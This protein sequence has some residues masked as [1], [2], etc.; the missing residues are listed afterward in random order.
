MADEPMTSGAVH[1]CE[2]MVRAEIVDDIYDIAEEAQETL[3][4]CDGVLETLG[5]LRTSSS[6]TGSNLALPLPSGFL[7]QSDGSLAVKY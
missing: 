4:I 3:Y 6:P 2:K 1:G 5:F 7:L